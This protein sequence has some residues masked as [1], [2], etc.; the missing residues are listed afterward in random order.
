MVIYE[1]KDVEMLG[2]VTSIID[3]TI[4]VSVLTLVMAFRMQLIE[5]H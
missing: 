4:P 5:N 1:W 2:K 3:D